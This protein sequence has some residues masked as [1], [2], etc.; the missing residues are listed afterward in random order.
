MFFTPFPAVSLPLFLP[1]N[2]QR[3]FSL[4]LFLCSG[5][6]SHC[7]IIRFL[8]FDWIPQYCSLVF[9]NF[10]CFCLYFLSAEY[11][12]TLLFLMSHLSNQFCL[13]CLNH[14][15]HRFGD[16]FRASKLWSLSLASYFTR[17]PP[18]LVNCASILISVR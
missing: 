8:Q 5:R 3:I 13:C 6:F 2:T 10:A 17:S 15:N 12:P 14:N 11:S 9:R 18:A 16:T 1:P 7:S 4:I